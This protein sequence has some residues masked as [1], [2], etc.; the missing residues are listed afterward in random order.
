VSQRGPRAARQALIT[1]LPAVR[2]RALGGVQR[3]IAALLAADPRVPARVVCERLRVDSYVALPS[4][5]GQQV[6]ALD[7]WRGPVDRAFTVA[8]AGAQQAAPSR[9]RRVEDRPNGSGGYRPD[10][11]VFAWSFILWR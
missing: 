9:T 2:C 5:L 8:V 6:L 7:M 1:H 4:G 11:L 3:P 10:P